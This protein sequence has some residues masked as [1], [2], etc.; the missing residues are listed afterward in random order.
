MVLL[1]GWLWPQV[2]VAQDGPVTLAAQALFYGDNT[3][4]SNPFREGE[5][6][7][8]NAARLEVSVDLGER[9]TLSGGVFGDRR[10]GSDDAFDLVRPVLAL[11]LRAGRS[12][13]TF[14]TFPMP[15]PAFGPDR[16]GP[17]HLLP[18]IQS[19]TLGVARTYEAGLEW[20]FDE[21]RAP[22]EAWIN[23]QRLN[24]AQRREVFDAGLNGRLPVSANVALAYQA[25]IVHHGGQLFSNGPV[26]DSYVAAP[27]LIWD[28]RSDRA[29]RPSVE[30]FG[31]VSRYVPNR[32]RMDGATSGGALF[33]RAALEHAKWR[34]HL[35]LWRGNDYIKEEGD[36]NYQGLRRDG[37]RFRRVRDY[38]ELGLTR[39]AQPVA[40]L[41]LESSARLHRIES[42][43]EYSY[44]ILGSVAL[45]WRLH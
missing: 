1:I 40:G 20:R 5:T 11:Q 42:H 39:T 45:G 33:T 34:G 25:H 32:E 44:R 18:P 3:E 12:R 19:D 6:L 26:A 31:L 29:W 17:H 37:T 4:F 43:Y 8:G 24:T 27:G 14:G 30:I 10:F 23:W 35:I 16:G 38:G 15:R 22:Q 28:T 36:A 2:A 13:Y 9:A 7:F 21:P 41:T